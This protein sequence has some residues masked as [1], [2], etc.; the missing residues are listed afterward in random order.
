MFIR[1]LSY[2][3]SRA[4][5][6][7]AGASAD[8]D[9]VSGEEDAD[10][11]DTLLTGDKDA[12]DGDDAKGGKDA[13][14][15]D[16][17]DGKDADDGKKGD[18]DG[19]K[20][21][22]KT[23]A[24]PDAAPKEYADFTLPEG[25]EIDKAGMEAFLP[26]AKE[27]DLSQDNAQKLVGISTAMVLAAEEQRQ[28]DWETTKVGWREE[29]ENDKEFGGEKLE[30][31]LVLIRDAMKEWGS[32]ELEKLMKSTGFGDHPAILRHFLHLGQMKA[33]DGFSRGGDAGTGERDQAKILFGKD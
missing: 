20:A 26:I 28:T 21:D 12:G 1:A 24:K 33:E 13:D 31:S 4:P 25:M 16:A 23:D 8:G 27:L 11:G 10:D 15:K 22:G 5:D 6:G 29:A 14:A 3:P 32:P 18:D 30:E 17:K 2:T 7:E 9:D 19:K